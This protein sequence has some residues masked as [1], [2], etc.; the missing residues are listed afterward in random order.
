MLLGSSGKAGN[1]RGKLIE[2]LATFLKARAAPSYPTPPVKTPFFLGVRGGHK[3]YGIPSLSQSRRYLTS[4]A[5]TNPDRSVSWRWFYQIFVS[6][7]VAWWVL[8]RSRPIHFYS[9]IEKQKNVSGSHRSVGSIASFT[10]P[11]RMGEG[12]AASLTSIATA[13]KFFSR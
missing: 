7:T 1:I 12:L 6:F 5:Y 13:K 2:G 9:V 8:S 3:I 4:Q 10:S 11:R